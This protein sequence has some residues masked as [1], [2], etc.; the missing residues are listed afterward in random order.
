MFLAKLVTS[1]RLLICRKHDCLFYMAINLSCMVCIYTDTHVYV[2]LSTYITNTLSHILFSLF[3]IFSCTHNIHSFLL[4]FSISQ[5]VTNIYIYIYCIY[6]HNFHCRYHYY[7]TVHNQY[8]NRLLLCTWLLSKP[9]K[10]WSQI[11]L[12]MYTSTSLRST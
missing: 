1:F 6:I 9:R 8:K 3:Y 2:C 5:I 4:S 12:W 11:E 10:R 7:L